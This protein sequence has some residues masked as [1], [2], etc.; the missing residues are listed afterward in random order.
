MFFFF[1]FLSSTLYHGHFQNTDK[2]NH[3]V[4]SPTTYL[5]SYQVSHRSILLPIY[6]SILFWDTF[7]CKLQTLVDLS[8]TPQHLSLRTIKWSSVFICQ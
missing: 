7:Q 6:Q 1:F 5:L 4:Q 3:T 2:V 8:P